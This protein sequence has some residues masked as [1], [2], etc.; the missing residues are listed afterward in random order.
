MLLGRI[1]R[2]LAPVGTTKE[3]TKDTFAA[4]NITMH[5]SDPGAESAVYHK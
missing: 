3:T 5:L 2:Y 1:L 4:N